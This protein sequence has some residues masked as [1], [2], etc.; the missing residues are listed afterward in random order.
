MENNYEP[1]CENVETKCVMEHICYKYASMVMS[2]LIESI[3]YF[4]GKQG[5]KVLRRILAKKIPPEMM[6]ALGI[7]S[8]MMQN[9]TEQEKMDTL[10]KIIASRGGPLFKIEK[11]DNGEY[12]FILHECH[13]LPYSKTKGFCNVTAGLMLG[14]AQMLT[15]ET[16]DIEEVQTIAHGGEQCEFIARKKAIGQ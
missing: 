10:P 3:D 1:V 8:S 6:V 9:A 15:N 11:K 14:F 4:A 2:G 12:R 16:M 13:F 5:P 7:D